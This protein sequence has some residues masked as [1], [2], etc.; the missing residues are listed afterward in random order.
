MY[1][2]TR[3]ITTA[4]PVDKHSREVTLL[5]KHKREVTNVFLANI[6]LKERYSH[7]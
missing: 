7:K 4:H 1:K 3:E 6:S 5:V 2:Y